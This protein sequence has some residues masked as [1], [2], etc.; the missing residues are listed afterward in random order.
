MYLSKVSLNFTSSHLSCSPVDGPS[1]NCTTKD[2]QFVSSSQP[3]T[4]QYH[5]TP[6][7]KANKEQGWCTFFLQKLFSPANNKNFQNKRCDCLIHLNI[8]CPPGKYFVPHAILT[9]FNILSTTGLPY[10][11]LPSNEV[12]KDFNWF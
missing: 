9:P 5:P 3:N 2:C 12:N 10:T 4:T 7:P 1:C 11:L 8:F 6:R